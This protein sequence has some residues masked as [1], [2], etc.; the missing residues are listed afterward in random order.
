MAESVFKTVWAFLWKSDSAWSWIADLI[1]AF[2]IVRLVFF[3]LAGLFLSSQ[4][5]LVVVESGSMYHNLDENNIICGKSLETFGGSFDDYWQACGSFYENIGITKELFSQWRFSGGFSKG[6]IMAIKGQE[7]YSI[8]DIIVFRVPEQST[9]IIHRIIKKSN[10]SFATKGDHNPVQWDYE[11]KI[12]KSQIIGKA[13][14]RIPWIGWIKLI[15]VE[16]VRLF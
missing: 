5:P 1:I 13:V 14:G 16:F 8:G 15:A 2:L 3:P 9:P 10:D 6:D 11:K 12:S 4:L 7:D